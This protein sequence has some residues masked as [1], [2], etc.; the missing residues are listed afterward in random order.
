MSKN[1]NPFISLLG[2]AV[3]ETLK[4]FE[5]RIKNSEKPMRE[6][7]N[8]MFSD[9]ISNNADTFYELRKK[10]DVLREK[11]QSIIDDKTKEYNELKHKFDCIRE[12]LRNHNK[13]ED[14]L[15]M[16]IKGLEMKNKELCKHI[17]ELTLKYEN[18]NCEDGKD[19]CE[20][21]KFVFGN[22]DDF[23]PITYYVVSN[24]VQAS[25]AIECLSAAYG[26]S[27]YSHDKT[28]AK[29]KMLFEDGQDACIYLNKD[30][31]LCCCAATRNAPRYYLTKKE[32]PIDCETP[33]EE[34]NYEEGD[35]DCNDD[36]NDSCENGCGCGSEAPCEESCNDKGKKRIPDMLKKLE[37]DEDGE[38]PY[39]PKRKRIV[40]K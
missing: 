40:I 10:Y 26:R 12:Q 11:A 20:D 38:Q 2:M 13:L 21:A 7:I 35:D 27:E 8:D 18:A 3:E 37:R 5:E 32:L 24:F 39:T 31:E 14:D 36:C 25:T 34:K 4:S 1:I 29:L 15:R 16:E 22:T 23:A 6:T 30:Y 28:F 19:D 9:I 17:E 33:A